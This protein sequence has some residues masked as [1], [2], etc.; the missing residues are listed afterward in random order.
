MFAQEEAPTPWCGLLVLAHIPPWSL[1]LDV[2]TWSPPPCPP[3]S[4]SPLHWSRYLC[5]MTSQGWGWSTI[6]T[7]MMMNSDGDK[8]LVF[9]AVWC[10]LVFKCISHIFVLYFS[11]PFIKLPP[12]QDPMWVGSRSSVMCSFT[13]GS[14]MDSHVFVISFLSYFSAPFIKYFSAPSSNH[15]LTKIGGSRSVMCSFTGRSS[16][17]LWSVWHLYLFQVIS[18]MMIVVINILILIWHWT[19]WCM[20]FVC[21]IVF[22][23]LAVYV[24]Q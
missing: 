8:T 21:V 7:T 14:Q 5:Q 3:W 2:A 9:F 4:R 20:C 12:Y 16:P 15:H 6:T 1:I 18:I 11:V 22:V 17:L 19:W 13:D 23:C 24:C 10:N